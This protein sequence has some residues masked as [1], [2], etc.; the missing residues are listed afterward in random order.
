MSVLKKCAHK[1]FLTISKLKNAKRMPKKFLYPAAQ[2]NLARIPYLTIFSV[3]DE[4]KKPET[5]KIEASLSQMSLKSG[6]S[7]IRNDIHLGLHAFYS[8]NFLHFLRRS[9]NVVC[10]NVLMFIQVL[11]V[12]TQV[13]FEAGIIYLENSFWQSF[14]E[15]K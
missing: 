1:K 5:G 4:E 12:L 6:M 15:T 11:T 9:K 3:F 8:Q 7:E 2:G 14:R 10:F 13:T